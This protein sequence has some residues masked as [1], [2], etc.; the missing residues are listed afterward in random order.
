MLDAEAKKKLV[1][2]FQL[3]MDRGDHDFIDNLLAPD[4]TFE[5]MES[6]PIRNPLTGEE[7]GPKLTR[8]EYLHHGVPGIRNITKDGMHFEFEFI[9]CDGAFVALF[10]S[11][12]GDGLNGKKYANRYCWLFRFTDDDKVDMKREYRDTYASRKI[13][14]E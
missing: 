5:N 3:A 4:F 10:G 12:D 13:L 8:A 11:S 14:F 6:E 7:F 9:L 1:C 2:E